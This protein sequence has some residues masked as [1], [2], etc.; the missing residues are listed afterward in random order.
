MK[1]REFINR[2]QE[3]EKKYP[4]SIVIY[5]IDDEGN[6]FKEVNF[7]PTAG[8]YLNNEFIPL[9]HVEDGISEYGSLAYELAV[10]IN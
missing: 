7:L 9:D 5:S 1:L 2:L 10:C 6:D 8:Y 4:D 3:M